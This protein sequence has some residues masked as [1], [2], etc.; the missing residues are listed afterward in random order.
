[1]NIKASEVFKI[2]TN[3]FERYHSN[4]QVVILLHTEITDSQTYHWTNDIMYP[5]GLHLSIKKK[6]YVAFGPLANY[7]DRATAASW[8]SL[9]TFADRGCCVVS[10]TDPPSVF[11]V[12][13]TKAATISSK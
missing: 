11:S 5:T 10:T 13:L 6:N 4:G 12:F 8:R 7:A 3:A 2:T 9:P 1:V